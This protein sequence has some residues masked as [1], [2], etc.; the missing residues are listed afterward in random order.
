MKRSWASSIEIRPS[1]A[2]THRARIGSGLIK[3]DPAASNCDGPA[4]TC[5]EPDVV[6]KIEQVMLLRKALMNAKLA[7]VPIDLVQ[8]L[9]PGYESPATMAMTVAE[10]KERRRQFKVGANEQI[11]E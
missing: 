7:V 6:A 3:E 2:S 11:G 10:I 4:Q 5:N 8:F 1:S 9:T